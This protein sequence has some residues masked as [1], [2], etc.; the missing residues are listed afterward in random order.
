MQQSFHLMD[1]Q[2][3]AAS[4]SF[5]PCKRLFPP[6]HPFFEVLY[7]EINKQFNIDPY[8]VIHLTIKSSCSMNMNNLSRPTFSL[9][10]TVYTVNK[11]CALLAVAIICRW[12][13]WRCHFRRSNGTYPPILLTAV[14]TLQALAWPG[15]AWNR[16]GLENLGLLRPLAKLVNASHLPQARPR[17][18]D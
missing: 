17:L 11:R 14:F 10:Y 4:W 8:S 2:C 1:V 18:A 9:S 16:P 15:L 6:R 7:V 3:S 13:R 5:K 12:K